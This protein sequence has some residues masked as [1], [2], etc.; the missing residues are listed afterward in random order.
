M[1]LVV[2]HRP[3]LISRGFSCHLPWTLVLDNDRCRGMPV[4]VAAEIGAVLQVLQVMSAKKAGELIILIIRWIIPQRGQR[5]PRV[6]HLGRD[7]L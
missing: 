3:A 6:V 2:L 1:F 4:P 7:V 5:L